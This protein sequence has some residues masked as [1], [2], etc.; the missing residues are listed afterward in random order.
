MDNAYLTWS[1]NVNDLY[2]NGGMIPTKEGK[3]NDSY[4]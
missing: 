2:D 3:A 4:D 1:K